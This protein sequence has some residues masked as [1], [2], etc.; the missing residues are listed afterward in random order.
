MPEIF[1]DQGIIL[2]LHAG[3]NKPET[4]KNLYKF[5]IHLPLFFF[6]FSFLC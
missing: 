5:I 1:E 2:L 4:N 6:F 3:K